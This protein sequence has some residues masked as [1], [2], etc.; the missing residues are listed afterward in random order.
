M[1]QNSKTDQNSKIDLDQ[2]NYFHYNLN[3]G[4]LNI[5]ASEVKTCNKLNSCY[6]VTK[7]MLL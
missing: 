5:T 2:G 1:N 6:I 4:R 7:V 3:Q